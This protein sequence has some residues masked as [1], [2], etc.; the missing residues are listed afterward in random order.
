VSKKVNID[1]N[2]YRVSDF[3]KDNRI[4]LIQLA[5]IQETL[6]QLHNHIAILTKAKN[7]YIS[8]IKAEI[9]QERTGVDFS[10]LFSDE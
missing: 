5:H 1:G 4:I 10:D 7:A 2:E 9:I 8:D 6:H 3:S